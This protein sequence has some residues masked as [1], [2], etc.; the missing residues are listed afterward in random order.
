MKFSGG[1]EMPSDTCDRCA[2]RDRATLE[3]AARWLEKE[4][5]RYSSADELWRMHADTPAPCD[6]AA[7]D[8]VVE[9]V[10]RHKL[11]RARIGAARHGTAEHIEAGKAEVDAYH[12]LQSAVAALEGAEHE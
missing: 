10:V 7:R 3:R 6:C 11:A 2:A 1:A 4:R 9:A 5:G 8:R 12:E